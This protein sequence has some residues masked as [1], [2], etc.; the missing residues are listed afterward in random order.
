MAS[1]LL[2]LMLLSSSYAMDCGDVP[3]GEV[4]APSVTAN[5]DPPLAVNEHA[6]WPFSG[7]F[8]QRL[9]C[10]EGHES[11]HLSFA[12]NRTSGAKGYLQWLDSTARAW[13]VQVGNRSSEWTAAAVIHARGEAFFRSQWPVTAR[14]C[15]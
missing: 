2:G 6:D 9:W 15:P 4:A 11:E 1:A 7:P 13:G 8:A 5:P 12:L 3:T 10:I 14:L